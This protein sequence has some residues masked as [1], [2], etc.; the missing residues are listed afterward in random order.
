[1]E[2]FSGV[3]RPR[4][5]GSPRASGVLLDELVRATM[6]LVRAHVHLIFLGILSLE[7]SK[8]VFLEAFSVLPEDLWSRFMTLF[9]SLEPKLARRAEVMSLRPEAEAAVQVLKEKLNS[10]IL[11]RCHDSWW[12]VRE[13]A[14]VWEL[15]WLHTRV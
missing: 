4:Q 13:A 10:G 5:L 15:T 2:S 11:E 6:D 14:I 3:S 1:M 7:R 8:F 12:G 9:R